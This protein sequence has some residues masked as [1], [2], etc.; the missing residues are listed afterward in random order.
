[1]NY[2]TAVFA[3]LRGYWNESEKELFVFRPRDHFRRFLESARLLRMELPFTEDHLT[4]A[5]TE[6]LRTELYREDCY[7]RPLA[8]YADESIGVR[9]HDLSPEV[10]IVAFPYG[11]YVADEEGVHATV[12]SW[13]RVD[14]NAIPARG[15]VAGAYVNSAL[16][17]SDAMAAGFDEAIMLNQDGHVSESTASN[18]FLVKNGTAVTAPTTDNILEGITRR[19]VMELLRREL[20]L[21]VI[22]RRIDRSEIYLADEAFFCGTGIQIAAVTRVDHR[23][24]G[25]GRIGATASALRKLYFDIVRGRVP[26]YRHWCVPIYAGERDFARPEPAAE[27]GEDRPRAGGPLRLA[28]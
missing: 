16:A 15:K 27:T 1:L 23:S 25:T 22:E 12:S 9:L 3:G 8:F 5:L 17:K 26:E 2:G 4:G 6:L 20:N 28:R 21:S 24:I 13:R 11:S 7:I 19:T 18:L 14:D 10:S